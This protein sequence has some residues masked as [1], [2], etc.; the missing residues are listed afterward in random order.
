MIYS[1]IKNIKT[2]VKSIP[3]QMEDLLDK[4]QMAGPLSL[5][6]VM[7]A[8][9]KSAVMIKISNDLVSL[10]RQNNSLAVSAAAGQT[11]QQH[12][13]LTMSWH[14]CSVITNTQTESTLEYRQLGLFQP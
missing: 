5:E 13:A 12:L 8:V 4:C 3:V 9:E 14:G 6:K 1:F 10:R 7:E 11:M 2:Q